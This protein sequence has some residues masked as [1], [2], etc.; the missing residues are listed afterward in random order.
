MTIGQLI[1]CL[2]G[3]VSALSGKEGDGTPFVDLDLEA[4]KDKLAEFGFDRNGTEY[5]YNGMTGKKMKIPIFIGPTYYQRLK[6][7]VNDKVNLALKCIL[8]NIC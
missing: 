4:V 1:E 7:L 6:H 8:K 3:K 5:L 2:V